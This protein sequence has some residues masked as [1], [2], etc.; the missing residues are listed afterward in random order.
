MHYSEDIPLPAERPP[1]TYG[2]KGA[3]SLGF[4][5]LLTVLFAWL[6]QMALFR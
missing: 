1:N 2:W 4:W 5:T 3:F 6:S